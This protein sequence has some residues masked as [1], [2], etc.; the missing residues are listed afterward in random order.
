MLIQLSLPLLSLFPFSF[1]SL[2][3]DR[4][5]LRNR[6]PLGRG[7]PCPSADVEGAAQ[8]RALKG[9]WQFLR[10][11]VSVLLLQR[12]CESSVVW[13]PSC[14]RLQAQEICGLSIGV[15][16]KWN[17]YWR[18]SMLLG[19]L[20]IISWDR[21]LILSWLLI[22][23]IAF[24]SWN[25]LNFQAQ[26]D[27]SLA[28]LHAEHVHTRMGDRGPACVLVSILQVMERRPEMLTTCVCDSQWVVESGKL[29]LILPP[30]SHCFPRCCFL[31]QPNLWFPH[32]LTQL[33]LTQLCSRIVE[34]SGQ[35]RGVSPG[36]GHPISQCSYL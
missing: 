12:K 18:W 25:E 26:C 21:W 3:L 4:K 16:I 19:P 17:G 36:T 34:Q 35:S 29:L 22:P 23:M 30:T 2:S 15:E 14:G 24:S 1:L 9:W 27:S 11:V 8:A 31:A 10:Q 33:C 32:N 6:W 5:Q 7:K 28:V 13:L 20:T